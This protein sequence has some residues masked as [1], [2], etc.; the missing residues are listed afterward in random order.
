MSAPKT[1]NRTQMEDWL[2]ASSNALVSLFA[3][4]VVF[5]LFQVVLNAIK[6]ASALCVL[7]PTLV[8]R[9]HLF[10]RVH[11]LTPPKPT[12]SQFLPLWTHLCR[13][14][15]CEGQADLHYEAV[16]ISVP[17]PPPPFLLPA[18]RA[19][20]SPALTPAALLTPLLHCQLF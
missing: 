11:P 18:R 7:T 17:P 19:R 4:V 8:S 2:S 6:Q 20:L 1:A 15:A 12:P 3:G 10:V 5:A 14:Q 13:L 16:R 9:R